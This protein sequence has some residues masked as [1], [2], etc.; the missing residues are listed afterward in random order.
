[1]DLIRYVDTNFQGP[2]LL[3]DVNKLQLLAPHSLF[4][5][6]YIH[7][8]TMSCYFATGS[9]EAQVCRRDDCLHGHV[10]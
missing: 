9:R 8:L 6:I 1:M 10:H 2:S 5:F 7:L 4:I 3:P